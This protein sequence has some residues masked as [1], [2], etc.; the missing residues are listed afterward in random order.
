MKNEILAKGQTRTMTVK[1]IASAIGVAESTIRNKIADLFPNRAKNGIATR[2]NEQQVVFLKKNLTP[3]NLTLKSKVDNSVT[4]LEM[5]EN[6]QRDLQ[7]LISYNAELQSQ[8]EI[9][10]LKLD[11]SKDWYSVKRMEKIEQ[12]YVV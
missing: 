9:L 11:E 7:W 6:V 2:L 3:M 12:R 1:E 10:Q 4:H 8:N 5:L